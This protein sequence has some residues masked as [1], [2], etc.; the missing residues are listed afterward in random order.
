MVILVSDRVYD[1]DENNSFKHHFCTINIFQE[2]E[3]IPI[4]GMHV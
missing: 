3:G 4:E 2:I 1:V